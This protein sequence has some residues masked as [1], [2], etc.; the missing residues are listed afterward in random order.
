MNKSFDSNKCAGLTTNHPTWSGKPPYYGTIFDITKTLN[1]SGKILF[2]RTSIIK[3]KAMELFNLNSYVIYEYKFNLVQ[4]SIF[5]PNLD[6]E[7]TRNEK[8]ILKD[9]CV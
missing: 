7:R 1:S 6:G 3:L 2:S 8:H 9:M 4:R 5:I